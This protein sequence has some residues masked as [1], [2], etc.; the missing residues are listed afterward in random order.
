MDRRF[1][2]LIMASNR[3]LVVLGWT[4][5]ALITSVSFGSVLAVAFVGDWNHGFPIGALS[6]LRF[7]LLQAGISAVICVVLAVP[8]SRALA[9]RSFVGR[10]SLVTLLGVPFL[11][12]ALVAVLGLLSIFGRSG[13]V[14]GALV[15]FG[16]QPLNIYGLP[17]ILLVHFFFN[18]PLVTRLILQG[19]SDIPSEQF[20]LA[21]QLD[22]R[23]ANFF[24]SLEWPMLRRVLPGAFLLV[25]LLCTTSFAVVLTMGGGPKATTLELAIFQALR[26]DFDLSAAAQLAFL[27]VLVCGFSVLAVALVQGKSAFGTTLGSFH[28]RSDGDGTWRLIA[29]CVTIIAASAFLFLPIISILF[30]GLP[31]LISGLP[32]SVWL[33]TFRSL[34]VAL[35]SSVLTV[36]FS[37]VIAQ[38]LNTRQDLKTRFAEIASY[39]PLAISPFVM[40]TGLFIMINPFADPFA[41][42]LVVTVIVN[43]CLCI[44]LALRGLIPAFAKARQ[45]YGRLALS[46]DLHGWTAFRVAFWPEIKQP[47]RFSA[48]IT[49]ALSMGDLGVIA[50]FATPDGGTLPLLMQRLLASY[51]MDAAAG[52]AALLLILSFGLFW[53]I[54]RGV[55][56]GH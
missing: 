45:R 13:P 21:A 37:L 9:C 11:L 36:F 44:P 52:V 33:A 23:G 7:T 10:R 25:F 22:M 12:P 17:G 6:S 18:L 51:Q 47:V 24:W 16:F 40:G 19:W 5:L 4:A 3:A 38:M 35:T 39:L 29:D 54:D 55:R 26:F 1:G 53:F 32:N 15:Y 48:A 43:T 8:L 28:N 20:R 46:L 30:T 31:A 2:T 49:A 50:L 41:L 27:Q 14:S 56:I 42:A 34:L